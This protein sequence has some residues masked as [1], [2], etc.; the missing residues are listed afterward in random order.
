MS[1]RPQPSHTPP[2]TPT[3]T[4]RKRGVQLAPTRVSRALEG[5]RTQLLHLS[6]DFTLVFNSTSTRRAIDRSSSAHLVNLL[7]IP[8]LLDKC[9]HRGLLKEFFLVL[10][11]S[12][13][14]INITRSVPA[15]SRQGLLLSF[16]F[17]EVLT[18][19]VSARDIM[20][21]PVYFAKPVAARFKALHSARTLD[22]LV[23]E[24]RSLLSGSLCAPGISSQ[25]ALWFWLPFAS[26]ADVHLQQVF[27]QGHMK[28]ILSSPRDKSPK[29]WQ[30]EV[31]IVI[32]TYQSESRRLAS[33]LDILFAFYKSGSDEPAKLTLSHVKLTML[34]WLT[35]QA[36]I[37]FYS[38]A[39]CRP[40]NNSSITRSL[41][42]S[43]I[44]LILLQDRNASVFP[45]HPANLRRKLRDLAHNFLKFFNKT[46][47]Q[48]I[49]LYALENVEFLHKSLLANV[50]QSII[51]EGILDMFSCLI[52]G[53]IQVQPTAYIYSRVSL[54]HY[55]EKFE[56]KTAPK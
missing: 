21:K 28:R 33:H 6:S 13:S 19:T 52:Y 31:A 16:F 25:L 7:Q 8:T 51:E 41:E 29:S 12:I 11:W 32:E 44:A 26:C 45:I 9:F 38:L 17:Q 23:L 39:F 22:R 27:L 40:Q 48:P 5:S 30:S 34:S 47:V 14:Q 56:M 46:R 15:M 37:I 10:W 36:R 1:P 50:I 20:V 18:L 42:P 2:S 43:A 54:M 35:M 53:F 55:S 49:N 24:I 3:Q 4:S